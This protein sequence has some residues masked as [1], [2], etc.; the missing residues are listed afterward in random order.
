M[1][2]K[3]RLLSIILSVMLLFTS[4]GCSSA[5]QYTEGTYTGISEN[6]KN[7]ALSVEVEFSKTEI[8][9]VKVVDFEETAGI[10]DTAIER[11]PKEV[12]EYQSLNVDII[13]GA[14]LTCEAIIEAIADCVEQAKGDVEALKTKE[15]NK[16]ESTE[17]VEKEADVVIIGAGA[18]GMGAAISAA[19]NGAKS[20]IVLEKTSSIGGNAIVSGGYLEYINAQDELRPENTAGYTQMIEGYLSAEP[21]SEVHAEFQEILKEE[22]NNYLETGST[23]VFDSKYLCALDYYTLEDGSDPEAMLSFAQLLEDT[24]AWLTELGMEWDDLTG[25]VGYSWPRWSSPKVGHEGQGYFKLFEESIEKNNYPIEI[26]TETPGKELI[27]EDGK[28]TGVVAKNNDGVE[29]RIKGEK[30][31]VIATGGFSANSEM[32]MKYNTM[33]EGLSAD[34][35][36]TNTAGITGDG[37]IMAQAVGADVELMDD[38]MLFPNADPISN[39]TENIVGNDGDALYINKEGKRFVNETSDRYTIS[40][41]LLEQTDKILYMI[42]DVENCLITD[43]ITTN[44][45]SESE[46]LE[47]KQLFKAD[48]LEDLAKQIDIDPTVLKESV[49]TY[50]RY[51]NNFK[52]EEFGR[53]SFSKDSAVDKG[54]FYALPRTVATHIT[55]GGLVRDDNYKVIDVKG[56]VIEGLYAGGE[57]T[58]YMSGISSF[59]DGMYIGREL[60]GK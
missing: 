59:G 14:T 17:V 52:D 55:G 13:T 47:N 29:Y 37:I 9:S 43:G 8:K 35:P 30:G 6:G 18:T 31:V 12:V 33:W 26:M 48:T 58:A 15:I 46:M 54:P 10:S 3:K 56:K 32:L 53:I 5:S 44:G 45:F 39:S 25:I 16:K 7:G 36:T 24:T 34:M 50:N 4:V 19:Q 28:V 49:E 38:I 57:V 1:K 2:N 42:S 11:I 41:A 23:K 40:E 21:R 27:F 60:L 22:Y 20:V 51:A